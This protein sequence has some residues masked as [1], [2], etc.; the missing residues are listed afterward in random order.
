MNFFLLVA[1]SLQLAMARKGSKPYG[2]GGKTVP[3]TTTGGN[4]GDGNNKVPDTTSGGKPG[5]KV[6][7]TTSG[8][9]TGDGNNTVPDTTESSNSAWGFGVSIP[10]VLAPVAA[11]IIL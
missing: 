5:D 7:D 9:N 10:I 8:G 2:K 3:D 4:P 11:V 1:L 6:P